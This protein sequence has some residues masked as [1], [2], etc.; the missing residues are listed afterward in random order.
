MVFNP[1][2]PELATVTS[3]AL[4]L[5]IRQLL[6]SQDGFGADLAAQNVIVPI[7]DLTASA[8]GSDVPEFL[9]TALAFGSQTSFDTQNTTTTVANTAG[10]YRII[11]SATVRNQVSGNTAASVR[12]TDGSTD[13]EVW[14][15]SCDDSGTVTSGSAAF[16]FILFLAPGES[17]VTVSDA[18]N[19]IISG[20]IRQVADVNGTLVQP[21]GFTPQ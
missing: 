17:C 14:Q 4:Q 9:Q 10:F 1:A 13:K 16:D 5:K 20:S 21:S 11:G 6:P 8:E 18:A 12:L 3:E 15:M 19:A 2:Q 7:I